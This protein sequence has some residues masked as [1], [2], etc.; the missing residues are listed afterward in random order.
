[1]TATSDPRPDSAAEL[2]ALCER[3]AT[4]AGDAAL[5][6]R[7]DDRPATSTKSSV[8]DLVTEHDLTAERSIRA[9]LEAER[10][11]DAVLGEEAGTREGTTR[12]RWSID[13]ID[14]TTNFFYGLPMWGTSVAVALDDSTVAGAVRLPALGRTYSA[15]VGGGA[16]CNGRPIAVSTTER[17]DS[18]LVATGFGYSADLRV[19]QAAIVTRLIGRVR[20][21]RRTGSAAVDLCLVAEGSV[22]AYFEEHLNDWDVSAGLLIAAEA[23]ARI[24]DLDG[25]PVHPGSVVAATPGVHHALLEV[26]AD[27]RRSD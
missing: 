21:I 18:T 24:S 10:P 5:T 4:E 11:D 13:P 3:L 25:G 23:G 6:H 17:I 9:T 14:G 19:S 8:T 27:A 7:G 2:R 20:D 12:Y 22:D 15:H 1:M 16:T 26:L